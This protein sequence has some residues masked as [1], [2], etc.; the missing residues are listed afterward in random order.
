MQVTER[1]H[2]ARPFYKCIILVKP[3]LNFFWLLQQME[4]I[5]KYVQ[6]IE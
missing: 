4:D 1:L 5:K 6:N 2:G 3:I